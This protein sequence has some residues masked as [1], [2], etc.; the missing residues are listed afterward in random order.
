MS[1]TQFVHCLPD[2][3][4]CPLSF[5]CVS[6][7]C[8]LSV[9]VRILICLYRDLVPQGEVDRPGIT[10]TDRPRPGRRSCP[11]VRRS[12][13]DPVL[14]PTWTTASGGVSDFFSFFVRMKRGEGRKIRGWS[15]KET[16]SGDLWSNVVSDP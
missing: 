1:C 2:S 8:C 15:Q 5:R 3:S 7:R 14:C 16:G 4:V 9:M 11:L 6:K 10:R 12:V 13:L